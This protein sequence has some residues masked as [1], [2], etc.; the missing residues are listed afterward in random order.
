MASCSGG[1]MSRCQVPKR[2]ILLV[3][4]GVT[5]A[6]STGSTS[7][8]WSTR[9]LTT[10]VMSWAVWKLRQFASSSLKEL[11]FHRSS[12]SLIKAMERSWCGS[13]GSDG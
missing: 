11:A 8:P 5:V 13:W 6:R 10:F 3:M 12:C 7:Q 1:S 9:P 2:R 4:Y